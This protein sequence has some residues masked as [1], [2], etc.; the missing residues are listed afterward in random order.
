MAGS[1]GRWTMNRRGAL[2]AA[3][4]LALLGVPMA[5]RSASLDDPALVD[6]AA[7]KPGEYVWYPDR[8]P[9]GLVA[10]I[11]SL[12]DQRAY[13]YRNG[14]R[15]G[16]STVSTGKAGHETPVGVFTILQKDANHHSSL[17]NDASM[18]Y[19]ERLTWSGVALHAGGLPGYPS[20]HG[21]VHLPLAFA[22][23]LFGVTHYGTPVIV[24]DAHSQ[25]AD[26]LHPGLILS[27]D[28]D[29]VVATAEANSSA[30]PGNSP[31]GQGSAPAD[32][33]AVSMVIS[34]ADAALTV[35][36]GGD[37]VYTAPVTI[38]DPGT[39]LGNVVY[40]LK[41]V[42]G[43]IAWT[44]V[45]FEGNGNGPGKVGDAIDRVTVAK[46]ANAKLATLLVPGSTMLITDLPAHP[47]TRS[48]D[49]FVVVSAAAS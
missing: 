14:I 47:G 33:V 2:K 23:L 25:P 43:D 49:D 22:K 26:V 11:V 16:V 39:P 32:A 15:I 8:A 45:S 46:E 35:L 44:A 29:A 38:R 37:V 7:L 28:A 1:N 48:D 9:Q 4:V 5:S 19:T 24:A 42:K 18:P 34:R 13:V 20:S 36:K 12:P 10:I 3:G 17:Y 41:D 30:A 21:C 6:I 40:V 31:A 27:K